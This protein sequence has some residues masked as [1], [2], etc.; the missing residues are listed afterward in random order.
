MQLVR[1]WR[2]RQPEE[3]AKFSGTEA[4][5]LVALQE[6]QAVVIVEPSLQPP[7]IFFIILCIKMPSYE[8]ACITLNV[9]QVLVHLCLF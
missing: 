5:N 2:P 9:F 6:E 8:C 3:G 7:K 1:A 4:T